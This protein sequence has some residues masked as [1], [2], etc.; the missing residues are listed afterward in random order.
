MTDILRLEPGDIIRHLKR[1]SEYEVMGYG[2]QH[3]CDLV[4]GRRYNLRIDSYG[5]K[6]PA[7]I[8]RSTKTGLPMPCMT[9]LYR[10]LEPKKGDPWLFIRPVSEFTTDRF[11]RSVA[12]IEKKQSVWPDRLMIRDTGL[13]DDMGGGGQRIYTTA[14]RGYERAEY[15]RSDLVSST[16]AA[17]IRRAALEEAAQLVDD[18]FYDAENDCTTDDRLGNEIR[19]LINT[20]RAPNEKVS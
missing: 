11:E 10:A 16:S 9:I 12:V 4:D 1:G 7:L 20:P 5:C 2:P 3:P 15:V 13:H 17:D 14:G 19:A 8:Q 18:W 6:I